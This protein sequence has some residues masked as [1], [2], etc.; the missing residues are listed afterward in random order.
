MVGWKYSGPNDELEAQ[1]IIGGHPF[2][3]DKLKDL[4][5]ATK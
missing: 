1:N 3:N 4:A 2:I 5:V